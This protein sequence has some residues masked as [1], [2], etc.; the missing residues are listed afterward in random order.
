MDLPAEQQQALDRAINCHSSGNLDE[1]VKLYRGL[2]DDCP[3]QADA[4]HYLGVIDLQRGQFDAAVILIQQAVD[5]R[6]GY[7]DAI[8]N[9]GYGLNALGRHEAAAEQFER[10]LSL[11]P[12][13]AT[14][15]ANL[16][17]SLEQMGRYD[18]AIQR[19]EA[20]LELQPELAEIRRSLADAL[21]NVGRTNDALREITQAVS[22]GRPS[23]AL[24]V[25]LG[26]ILN[27][28]GRVDDAI[29]CFE[30]LLRAQS[31]LPIHGNLAKALR[32]K[33]RYKEAIE[34]YEK[35]LAK[36]P[37]NID[38]HFDL[39]VVYHDLGEKD[40]ARIAF[41]KAVQLDNT[42]AKAWHGISTVSKNAFDDGEIEI[43]LKLQRD[44]DTS[45]DKRV[46]L[47]FALG[48]HFENTGR[49][50]DAARQYLMANSLKREEFD[51]DI[52][53]DL[54]AFHNIQTSFDETLLEKWSSAGL[55]DNSPIFIIGMPRSGTTLIEQILASHPQ[56]HGAGEREILTNSI[57]N[58]FPITNGSDYTGTLDDATSEKFRN[59]ASNYLGGFPDIVADYVTDKMP[60]NFLHVG[61][62]RILFP[63]ASIVHCRRNP[64]DTCF[65]IYK[66][67]F[68]V[69]SHPY[70]YDLQELARYYNAY[71]K[72]MN[73]WDEVMPGEIHTVDYETMI[74]AQEQTTRELLDACG[75]EWDP[76][77]LEF[78]KY[79]RPIAT[80]SATQVRQPVYR[81][82]IGAWKPYEKMLGPLL[83]LLN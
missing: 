25:S 76:A 6:P 30:D 4:L 35:L 1:A 66:H 12:A 16:G 41:R 26:N 71:A 46:L 55:T 2:L 13:K 56:V 47:A 63:N 14:L 42:C 29:Q 20:A 18:D 49:H 34:Q 77:C 82:S 78:H 67:L 24:K 64:H 40:D 3:E 53:N 59:V 80:I 65:S 69:R 50:E 57:L 60:H 43:L 7:V 62:I 23:F 36:D 28:A 39:G 75:L 33:G 17:G 38:G 51:Y 72:L 61:M 73:H 44:S 79:E 22:S 37:D 74:D 32:K 15:L 10:A 21:L 11:G 5:A 81:S 68:G 48:K 58:V 31:D 70:A 54:R 9:L 45:H 8:I 27:A 19:Y 52:E 83:A